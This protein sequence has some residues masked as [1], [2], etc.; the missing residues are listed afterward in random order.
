MS[1]TT[2]VNSSTKPAERLADALNDTGMLIARPIENGCAVRVESRAKH[3]KA[4]DVPLVTATVWLPDEGVG[5]GYMWSV[6]TDHELPAEVGVDS[7]VH[8]LVATLLPEADL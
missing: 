1:N 6:P 7:V 5:A 4:V 2:G 8:A 3:R